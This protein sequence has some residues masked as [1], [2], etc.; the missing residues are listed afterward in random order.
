MYSELT[1]RESNQTEVLES[2]KGIGS[3]TANAHRV[4]DRQAADAMSNQP[5]GDKRDRR[6]PVQTSQSLEHTARACSYTRLGV[7]NVR[8]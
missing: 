5:M 6:I 3:P 8:L 7:K 4:G 1:G 2:M